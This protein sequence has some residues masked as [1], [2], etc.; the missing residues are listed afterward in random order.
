MLDM[1]LIVVHV[2]VCVCVFLLACACACACVHL[3]THDYVWLFECCLR[4]YACV[5]IVCMLRAFTIPSQHAHFWDVCQFACT[6]LSSF[7]CLHVLTLP[8]RMSKLAIV[9]SSS[10][11]HSISWKPWGISHCNSWSECLRTLPDIILN[12]IFLEF[13]TASNDILRKF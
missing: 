6:I 8:T 11:R 2:C 4:G 12:P 9:S 3:Y 1:T 7:R 5:C 10:S 13:E